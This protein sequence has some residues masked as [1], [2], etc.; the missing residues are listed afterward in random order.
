MSGKRYNTKENAVKAIEAN[1]GKVGSNGNI[2]MQQP[3]IRM[4]G[5]ID[6]LIKLHGCRWIKS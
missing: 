2:A 5:A 3:G 6:F 1:G 4:L